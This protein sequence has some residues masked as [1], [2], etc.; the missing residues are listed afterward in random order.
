MKSSI[1]LAAGLGK[2]VREYSLD[3]RKMNI[4]RYIDTT[5]KGYVFNGAQ[6]IKKG[7]FKDLKSNVFLI[8]QV[9][10]DLIS[11]N[12]IKGYKFN[13]NVLHLGTTAALNKYDEIL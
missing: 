9:L 3:L 8:N 10:D 4:Q 11:K 1:I 5:S 6:I 2:R 7:A 13:K 12:L